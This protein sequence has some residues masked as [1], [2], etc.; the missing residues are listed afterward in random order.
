MS[1]RPYR[2]EDDFGIPTHIEPPTSTK[3]AAFFVGRIFVPLIM[4]VTPLA[5][6]FLLFLLVWSAFRRGS[7]MGVRSLAAAVLPITIGAFV[8]WIDRLQHRVNIARQASSSNPQPEK[9]DAS[10]V[11]KALA[12][13]VG[14]VAWGLFAMFAIQ[15]IAVMGLARNIPA[16]ELVWSVTL[17]LLIYSHLVRGSMIWPWYL[18]IVVGFLS[19]LVFVGM[20]A[21]MPDIRLPELPFWG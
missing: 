17:S 16:A 9:F 12:G 4:A 21:S 20:P 7:E 3:A 5:I 18:G 8:I 2:D 15:I 1:L 6:S 14:G 19:Y 10:I 11:S 13:F